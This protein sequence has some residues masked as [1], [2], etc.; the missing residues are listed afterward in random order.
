MPDAGPSSRLKVHVA[1][2][3]LLTAVLLLWIATATAAGATPAPTPTGVT[4]TAGSSSATVRWTAPATVDGAPVKSFTVTASTGQ[5]MTA[6]EPNTWAI[7]PGLTDG[8]AVTFTV[9]AASAAG[10]SAPSAP[11]NTITP[12]P[13]AGPR[14]VLR[15]APESVRYD[16]YSLIVG[17]RRVLVWAGEFDYYRLPSPS[18]WI[19]R[20]EEM[21]AAGFNAVSIYFDWDYHSPAPGVYDFSG[22]RD[23]NR[24]LNDAQRVGLY[25]IAR[26][27]PYINAETDAG[28]LAGWLASEPAGSRN[29]GPQYLAAA[30]QWLSEVDPI[31]AAHQITRGGDVIMY[32]IENEY[33][34]TDAQGEAYFANLEAQA[35]QDGIN[36]PTY[37][38]DVGS[39]ANGWAP[40]TPDAPDLMGSDQYPEGFDCTDT[41][42]FT[43]PPVL[44][45]DHEP[46]IPL[47]VPEY[48]GGSFDSWGGAGYPACAQLTGP[49][50]E[51][52]FYKY[53]IAQGATMQSIYMT[54][55]GTNWGFNPAPFMYTSYDYGSPISE[56]GTLSFKYPELKLV[57]EM[58]Q[59]LPDLTE[60]DQVTPPSIPGLTT[61][62]ER[63]PI[64]GTTFLY[65]GND[66]SSTVATTLPYDPSA[67]VTV[68]AHQ[69]KFLVSDA[70]LGGQR[71]VA[72]TSELV[73][74]LAMGGREVALLDGDAGTSGETTL[75]Y[76][77]RPAVHVLANSSGAPIG[78]SWTPS[79]HALKLTYVHSG[80]SEVAIGSGP[81]RLLLLLADSDT[82]SRFWVEHTAGGPLLIEGAQLLRTA[83]V[84]GDRAVL[85]GDTSASGLL[86]V[87]APARVRTL[88]WD[89][90]PLASRPGSDGALAAMLPGPPATVALPSLSRGWR[91]RFGSAERLPG[92]DDSS[93]P[94]ADHQVTDN[95]IQPTSPPVL[96]AQDYGF[97]H[98]FVWYRGHFTASGSETGITLT[99]D[100]GPFGSFAVWINGV[101]LGSAST[102][103]STHPF[104]NMDDTPLTQ[105][106]TFP[107]GAVQ[108]GK[109][110]VIAVLA[111]NMGQDE[112]F[113]NSL[114][115]DSNKTPRGLESASLTVSAGSAPAVTWRLMGASA[116]QAERD[117]VRGP[118][119]PAG[120]GESN[121]GWTLPGYPD[122]S[123]T[124]VNLPDSWATRDVPPG[125]GWYRTTFSLHI[126]RDVWAPIGLR[127]TPPGGGAPAPGKPA[128]QALIYLNG[129]LIGRYIN[130]LGPQN[131]FYLPQGLLRT[132]GQ[133]TLAV[134]EWSLAGGAGGLGQ[135]S[136]VPY[137]ILRGGIPVQ[138]VP[139]PGY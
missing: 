32:Q 103:T 60:T 50:F 35:K 63:N 113:E 79:T 58:S 47:M 34:Y 4:A 109:D 43:A 12:E 41:N 56:P 70:H 38:N 78:V 130:D 75:S 137:E 85:T 57:G 114:S 31:I 29:P 17:G 68:P 51:N 108:T 5:T 64:T 23:I 40:G 33:G 83:T 7:V 21:K 14:D 125:V 106:F 13:V 66:G 101:Y 90:Q 94:V 61:F 138:N 53:Y 44:T 95:P 97:E 119:N 102:P 122:A 16:Q 39:Y 126:P 3:C 48:Q 116:A 87:W 80:L 22:V 28:G 115:L 2:L 49:D 132:S 128:F 52:A 124:T 111:E 10:T 76:P 134:A 74:Q 88:S 25:V 62:E 55:G 72:T 27:G 139:D 15:G 136:L 37:T 71:L 59:A 11:S 20:L 92:F 91:F 26:P 18:L 107:S 54:V 99:A 65:L 96:Y 69:A 8:Q 45:S 123:W 93:W 82:A 110:N 67:T 118:T 1:P 6:D 19:D 81:G 127:L 105:T 86:R 135:V 24:L 46:G 9:T 30:D 100:T 73:T 77:R 42:V 120:L 36:V 98:G 84:S 131:T 121:A 117:P 129:W 112:S 89:S 104:A 133:N